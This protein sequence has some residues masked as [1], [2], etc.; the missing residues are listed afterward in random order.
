MV[1]AE[2][3]WELGERVIHVVPTRCLV[4]ELVSSA[5]KSLGVVKAAG[6]CSRFT[7]SLKESKLIIK[8]IP[9]TMPRTVSQLLKDLVLRFLKAILKYSSICPIRFWKSAYD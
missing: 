4:E 3:L 5:N 6:Q 9:I 8:K 1:Y 2:G 7:P